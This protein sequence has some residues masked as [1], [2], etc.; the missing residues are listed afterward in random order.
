ME[1]ACE[2]L[3]LSVTDVLSQVDSVRYATTLGTNAL[4]QRNGPKVALLVSAGYESSVPLS[5]GCGYA[6]SVRDPT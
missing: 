3:K 1:A 5:R 4:I 2:Q 6:R